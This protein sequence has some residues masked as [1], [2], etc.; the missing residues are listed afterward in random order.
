MEL[1]YDE[2]E[3]M[4]ILKKYRPGTIDDSHIRAA[5]F[6][7][8]WDGGFCVTTECKVNL[9]TREIFDIQMSEDDTDYQTLDEE[10][11]SFDGKRHPAIKKNDFN[12][13]YKS[14]GYFWYEG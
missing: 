7:S 2:G 6:T 3:Q 4:V 8:V 11:V 13:T 9:D 14:A 10:Y 5:K 1:L 12:E